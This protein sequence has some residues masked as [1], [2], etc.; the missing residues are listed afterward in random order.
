M[1]FV[2]CPDSRFC[3][4]SA[5]LHAT[6]SRRIIMILIRNPVTKNDT[7]PESQLQLSSTSSS[8][9][10]SDCPRALG[11]VDNTTTRVRIKVM[12]MQVAI[13]LKLYSYA[14]C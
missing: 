3:K 1:L 9:K 8:R 7:P 2:I 11:S 6:K 13:V 14:N 5:I 12:F 10:V 4:F